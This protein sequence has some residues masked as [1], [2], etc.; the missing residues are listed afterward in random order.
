[1]SPYNRY[2]KPDWDKIN[3]QKRLYI[4]KGQTANQLIGILSARMQDHDVNFESFDEFLK[5]YEEDFPKLLAV[6]KRLLLGGDED[7]KKKN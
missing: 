1:M 5:L 2:D 7:A 3:G 4:I 6:N